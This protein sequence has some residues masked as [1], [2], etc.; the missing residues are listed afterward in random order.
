MLLFLGY[1]VVASAVVFCSIKASQYIDMLDKK[2]SLSGAF[3]GGVL[4]SAVTSLPELFTSISATMLLHKPSLC[5]G[6]ILGSNLFNATVLAL[7]GIFSIRYFRKAKIT[8]GNILVT[9]FVFVIYVA[10]LLNM[11]NVL[12]L[13]VVTVNV[14][15]LV[16]LALYVGGVRY[17]A[18]ED[19][20]ECD[21]CEKSGL[22][23]RQIVVRFV[24]T[25]IAIV[26]L[27]I[28]MTYITDDIASTYNI[29]VGLA[30]AIFLGVAT[31]LPEVSS[32]IALFRMRNYNVA[33]GNIVGS[34]LFNFLVLCVADVLCFSQSIYD[35]SDNKVV[36]LLQ[37]GLLATLFVIVMLCGRKSWIKVIAGLVVVALYMAFLLR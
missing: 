17:L 6:N 30:G 29:G 26:A 35:Y 23:I 36:G 7:C 15:T 11:L 10:L 13:E 37:S 18:N 20:E 32:T 34:N 19:G 2:S 3:L 28:T 9:L 12:N 14:V 5:I 22:S 4:L 21:D 33:V 16:I 27:S 1:I 8:K 31:S 25:S 24:L